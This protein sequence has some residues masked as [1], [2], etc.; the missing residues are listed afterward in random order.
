MLI[1][2]AQHKIHF[3]N[4]CATLKKRPLLRVFKYQCGSGYT[5]ILIMSR[6]FLGKVRKK[7]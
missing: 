3:V 7:L 6:E 4:A 5:K 1:T 2:Q